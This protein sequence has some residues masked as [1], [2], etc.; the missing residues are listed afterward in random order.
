VTALRRR[1]AGVLALALAL[2]L[3]LPAASLAVTD[4]ELQNLD[5]TSAGPDPAPQLAT[6]NAAGSGL[7]VLLGLLAVVAVIF[8]VWWI[9]KRTN[10]GRVPGTS[11]GATGGIVSVLSTTS[12]G[13]NRNL[14]LV[15]VGDD[16]LL[17]GSTEHG[18]AALHTLDHEAA[19][20]HGLLGEDDDVV[21][22]AEVRPLSELTGPTAGTPQPPAARP[23]AA[24]PP[25]AKAPKAAAPPP[26]GQGGVLDELRKRTAR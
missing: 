18:I 26:A 12:V 11:R 4:E 10:R 19:R 24:K 20:E 9:L 17:L 16:V 6:G 25:R 22:I 8:V 21:E 2:L 14:H 15:R 3:A 13:P 23:P 7:R 5:T 1:L